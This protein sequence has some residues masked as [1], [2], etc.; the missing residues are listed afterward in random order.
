VLV[1]K[2]S[3]LPG[4]ARLLQRLD[5]AGRPWL[6]VTNSASRLPETLAAELA[7]LGVRVP[8][9]QIMTSGALLAEHFAAAGLVGSRC[10]VLGPEHSRIYARRAGGTVVPL[11]ADV[12]AD[13]L[14]VADQKDVRCPEDLNLAVSLMLRHFDGGRPLALLLCNPDLIYP[15]RPGLFG[16]T[17]GGLAAMLEAVLHERYPDQGP[18]FLRLGK[19]NRPIFDAARRRL[20]A[21]RPLMIGDQLGTDIF[22]ARR[23]GIDAALV[24][25]GLGT[26]FGSGLATAAVRRD[27]EPNWYLPSLEA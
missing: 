15:V 6:V 17:A 27:V 11:Q 18:R 1:D 19:P 25:T 13:V 26:G 3:A 20:G 2:Q 12:D 5:E 22:G 8:P 14:I 4:A 9:E 16:F 7:D 21:T 10:V 24:G 23:S